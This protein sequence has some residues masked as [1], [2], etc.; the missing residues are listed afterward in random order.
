M[1][2]KKQKAKT[3]FLKK[4]AELSHKY[5]KGK[6]MTIPKAQYLALIGLMFGILLAFHKF[7]RPYATTMKHLLN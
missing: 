7:L 6:I 3:I 4:L 2:H 5:Y 1:K